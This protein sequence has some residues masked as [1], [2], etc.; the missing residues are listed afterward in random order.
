VVPDHVTT[1]DIATT[2]LWRVLGDYGQDNLVQTMTMQ[3]TAPSYWNMIQSGATTVTEKWIPAK[4]RSH[5]H[6]MYAGI[7]EW[8]Y[9]TVGGI[10]TLQPGYAEIQLKP[11]LP[12]G[13]KQVTSSYESVRGTVASDIT[14]DGGKGSWTV[15][16]P[17]N[18]TAKVYI[19]TFDV[20]PSKVSIVESGTSIWKNGAPDQR[21]SGVVFDRSVSIG[22]H[23]Y[24]VWTLGSGAYQ[25]DWHKTVAP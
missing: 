24:V 5:N 1:G 12:S 22:G 3:P 19:P 2:Y 20:A 14:H 9:R 18:A 7:L 21:A 17:V 15:R 13:L 8:L 11:G 10:C 25:F 16:I 4:T 23:N 6:D